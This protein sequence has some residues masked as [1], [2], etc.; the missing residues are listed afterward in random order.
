MFALHHGPCLD[1]LL[2]QTSLSSLR[3]LLWRHWTGF[4]QDWNVRMHGNPACDVFNGIKMARGGELAGIGLED[5]VHETDGLVDMLVARYDEDAVIFCPERQ[6]S[7]HELSC[8]SGLIFSGA[9]AMDR[10]S[11]RDMSQWMESVACNGLEKRRENPEHIPR[12]I[13][14]AKRPPPPTGTLQEYGPAELM[15]YLTLGIYG[16]ESLPAA[17]RA[18]T[19][20]YFIGVE[21]EFCVFVQCGAAM[22]R[23]RRVLYI[24][25]PFVFAFLFE[26][27]PDIHPPLQHRLDPLCHSLLRATDLHQSSDSN[28]RELIYD[29]RRMTI[30]TTIP[31]IPDHTRIDFWSRS[32]AISMHAYILHS[33]MALRKQ[34]QQLE[35]TAQT[36]RGWS[37]TWLRLPQLER[38][39][40]DCTEAYVLC[41]PVPIATSTMSVFGSLGRRSKVKSNDLYVQHDA[42]RHILA[43]V[44]GKT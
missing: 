31:N 29:P 30:R 27:G 1:E 8:D 38:A 12:S 5:V 24:H 9:G 32:E 13:T 15:K 26:P 11:I 42:R 7:C 34:P 28:V 44:T 18:A 19:V 41:K 3:D 35:H 17:S 40:L 23:L 39:L 2:E 6:T 37:F 21:D 25:R 16:R 10:A 36:N 22:R 4:L 14:Q 43:L 20:P 33:Y